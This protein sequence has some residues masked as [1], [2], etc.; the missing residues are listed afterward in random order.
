MRHY[1]CLFFVV[2]FKSGIAVYAQDWTKQDSLWLERVLN[3][4]EKI[5][6]N[7]KTRKAIESGTF[8]H[9]PN[10]S[11]QLKTSPIELPILKSFEGVTSPET[12]KSNRAS[13]ADVPASVYILTILKPIDTI[14]HTR[15]LKIPAG[16]TAT[17]FSDKTV[18]ELKMLEA[19]TPKKAT[20]DDKYS[21]PSGAA[22]K[23][24]FEDALRSIF[25]PS[26]RAKQRNAKNANAWK[27]YND[28]Y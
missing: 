8:L 22:H 21:P 23:A 6:L 5:Q 13:P 17:K 9:D 1:Y 25:W 11:K 15:I 19:F 7:E 14:P 3:G 10:I 18:N 27:T 24:N 2:V 12:K 20:V 28:G 26:H 16:S 4:T